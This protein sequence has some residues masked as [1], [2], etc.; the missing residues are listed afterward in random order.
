MRYEYTPEQ[1]KWRDQVR[2]FV[3]KHVTEA[4]RAEMR[5]AGNEG[6]GPLALEF[7]RQLFAKGWWGVAWPKE[8]GGLGLTAAGRYSSVA[9]SQPAGA[10]AMPLAIRWLRRPTCAS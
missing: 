2:G 10:P 9:E 1:I 4:L 6:D 7:H 3:R 8:Y 5:Q